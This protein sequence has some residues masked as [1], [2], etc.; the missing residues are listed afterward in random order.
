MPGSPSCQFESSLWADMS[1]GSARAGAESN[2]GRKRRQR[3]SA[4]YSSGPIA[5]RSERGPE[6]LWNW[7][8]RDPT[9]IAKVSNLLGLAGL[10]D[11]AI[12]AQTL[13]V[14][15]DVIDHIDRMTFQAERR[16]D[17]AIQQIERRREDFA[18]RARAAVKRACEEKIEDVEF[19]E[20]SEPGSPKKVAESDALRMEEELRAPAPAEEPK[21]CDGTEDAEEAGDHGR[22]DAKEPKTPPIAANP[23]RPPSAER[24][25]APRPTLSARAHNIAENFEERLPLQESERATDTDAG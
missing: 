5:L 25:H 15:L 6:G 9:A 14:K 2:I 13:A 19:K 20:L 10:S 18:A 8:R 17:L 12:L 21:A 7:M 3:R 23:E 1:G 24:E 16:R 11:D 22:E 4:I